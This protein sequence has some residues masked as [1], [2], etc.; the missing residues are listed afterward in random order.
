MNMLV[1]ILTKRNRVKLQTNTQPAEVSVGLC[2]VAPH[3]HTVNV[4]V[5]EVYVCLCV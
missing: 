5:C 4:C 3:K 2:Q 1:N